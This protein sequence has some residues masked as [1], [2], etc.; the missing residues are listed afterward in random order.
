M[1]HNVGR[2]D[3]RLR[4]LGGVMLLAGAA[5]LPGPLTLRVGLFATMGLYLLGTALFSTCLGYRLLG[6]S[7]CPRELRQ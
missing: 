6:R 2:L 4:T 3:R 7:T 5:L 1:T